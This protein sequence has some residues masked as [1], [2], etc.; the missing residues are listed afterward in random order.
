MELA[1]DMKYCP[2]CEEAVDC[3]LPA[4]PVTVDEPYLWNRRP[5]LHK[6]LMDKP[7]KKATWEIVSI[8][9]IL[10]IMITMTLNFLLNKEIS[11]SEYPVTVCLVLFSYISSFAFL[12]SGRILKFVFVFATASV[13]ILVLNYLADGPDW[14][15]LPGIPLLFFFNV[16]LLGLTG[17]FRVS[18]QRG[19]NLIAYSFLAA[20]LLSIAVEASIDLFIGGSIDLVW[21]LI[22]SACII[23]IVIFLLFMHFRLRRGNDLYRTFHI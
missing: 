15:I 1:T 23:P 5:D 2:L 16:I 18:K 10:I 17:I 21:S 4:H 12:N 11:W 9:L 6:N 13:L 14:A 19:I 22:I 3:S 20:A 7:Q 8:V